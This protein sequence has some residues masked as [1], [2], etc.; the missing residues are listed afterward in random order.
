MATIQI[1]GWCKQCG[2]CAEMCPKNV[3]DY[4]KGKT[5]AVARQNDCVGCKLCEWR[6]PDFAITVLTGKEDNG[7]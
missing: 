2:L 1:N 5:P 6:C 3:F 7:K 4:A